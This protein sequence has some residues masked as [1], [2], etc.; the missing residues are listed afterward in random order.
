LTCEICDTPEKCL[1][2]EVICGLCGEFV[3]ETVPRDVV[4]KLLNKYYEAINKVVEL[5]YKLEQPWWLRK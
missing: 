3:G 4:N 1:G 5:E 2:G